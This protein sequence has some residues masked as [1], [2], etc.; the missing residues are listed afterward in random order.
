M[1]GK[2]PKRDGIDSVLPQARFDAVAPGGIEADGVVAQGAGRGLWAGDLDPLEVF[3]VAARQ[4]QAG[5]VKGRRLTEVP[6]GQ[7]SVQVR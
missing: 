5:S 2:G 3:M 4:G 7:A 6:Q 1:R